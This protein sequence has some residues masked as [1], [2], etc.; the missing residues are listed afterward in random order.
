MIDI[1]VFHTRDFRP[2]R[3]RQCISSTLVSTLQARGKAIGVELKD[4]SYMVIF[5]E[6]DAD[7]SLP[8][9]VV[10]IIDLP[11]EAKNMVSPLRLVSE[12]LAEMLRE[13]LAQE[14]LSGRT[15][16]VKLRLSESET[17]TRQD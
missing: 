2:T 4:P 3:A 10:I 7:D 11:V 14:V 13:R 5:H 17:S 9:E 8:C 1:Q 16:K 12:Q 6:V 15:I